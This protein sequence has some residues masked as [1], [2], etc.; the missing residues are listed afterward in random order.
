[1]KYLLLISLLLIPSIGKADPSVL[2]TG[3]VPA[4]VFYWWAGKQ[5]A[6]A[7]PYT[8]IS[9]QGVA[10][11]EIITIGNSYGRIGRLANFNGTQTSAGS[12]FAFGISTSLVT[13]R[14]LTLAVWGRLNASNNNAVVLTVI[15]GENEERATLVYRFGAR[16]NMYAQVWNNACSGRVARG[17]SHAF[18]SADTTTGNIG[19]D[20]YFFYIA[21]FK[22]GEMLA[23]ING[24]PDL[25]EAPPTE[26]NVDCDSPDADRIIV[27][28]FSISSGFNSQG[29]PPMDLRAALVWDVALSTAQRYAAYQA[30]VNGGAQKW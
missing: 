30:I 1:M 17:G 11:M 26:I 24:Q 20:Q 5:D 16:P 10:A 9:T 29:S 19:V 4:P 3:F 6:S 7:V 14:E 27:G 28:Q 13:T 21:T 25:L 22:D 12:R 18:F 15:N 23:D 2:N 8:E